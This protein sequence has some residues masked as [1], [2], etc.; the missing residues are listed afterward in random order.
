MGEMI[1]ELVLSASQPAE[2][3]NALERQPTDLVALA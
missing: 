1:Q 3:I 2:Q